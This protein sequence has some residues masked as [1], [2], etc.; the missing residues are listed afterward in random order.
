MC[1]GTETSLSECLRGFWGDTA[2]CGDAKDLSCKCDTP[3]NR[4]Q[5]QQITYNS[6]GQQYKI[7]LYTQSV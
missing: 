7:G 6:T 1:D 4:E 3:T 5:Q 2:L